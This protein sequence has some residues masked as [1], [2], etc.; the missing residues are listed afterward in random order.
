MTVNPS[1]YQNLLRLKNLET[2]PNVRRSA[3][4]PVIEEALNP[5]VSGT[6]S[7]LLP[8]T[9]LPSSPTASQ[10]QTLPFGNVPGMFGIAGTAVNAA[11]GEDNVLS[12]FGKALG[13]LVRVIG[14]KPIPEQE[15]FTPQEIPTPEVSAPIH[16]PTISPK[17][18]KSGMSKALEGSPFGMLGSLLK[19]APEDNVIKERLENIGVLPKTEKAPEKPVPETIK[20]PEIIQQEIVKKTEES[21]P[22]TFAEPGA[23]DIML[24][25]DAAKAEIER[26]FGTSFTPEI[27]KQLESYE[28]VLSEYG[29]GI[30]QLTQRLDEQE[31]ALKERIESRNLTD[32]D[33]LLMAIT[34]IAPVIVGALMGGGEGAIAGLGGAAR[35]LSE[36]MQRRDKEAMTAQEQLTSMA[37]EKAKILKEKVNAQELSREYKEKLKKSVPNAG[38]REIFTKDGVLIDGE[39]ALDTGSPLLPLKSNAVRDEK[40]VENFK[41][42]IPKLS[43]KVANSKKLLDSF[44]AMNELIH[45]AENAGKQ[46]NALQMATSLIPG[47]E[48][49]AKEWNAKFPYFSEYLKDANGNPVNIGQ[50]YHSLREAAVDAY[51]K[52]IGGQKQA[53]FREHALGLIPDPF[54]DASKPYN[55]AKYELRNVENLT[56][57][58]LYDELDSKG[59]NTKPI[60]AVFGKIGASKPTETEKKESLGQKLADIATGKSK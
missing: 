49:I 28:K 2:L 10:E 33:K 39:L 22:L 56:V 19:T 8:P 41:K 14:E 48:R 24:N 47:Y 45:I 25:D 60:K 18:Q 42:E 32:Q 55:T 12:R 7:Q 23:T 37:L 21:G 38:L 13:D 35:G 26:I 57:N 52:S 11:A 30:D 9:P 58:G 16:T 6:A 17:E 15:T 40:D 44:E 34:L 54:V 1:F 51:M 46:K 3:D 36:A 29:K 50:A 43:E 20:T 53:G 27:E 5:D 31:I 59:V 4:N